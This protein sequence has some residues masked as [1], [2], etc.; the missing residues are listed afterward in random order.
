MD[1]RIRHVEPRD[2]AGIKALLTDASVMLG[3]M[4]LPFATDTSVESRIVPADGVYKLVAEVDSEVVGFCIMTTYP[5]TRLNR[6]CSDSTVQT[7]RFG[8]SNSV[9]LIDTIGRKSGAI[10]IG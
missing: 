5:D 1:I 4:R 10:L 8:A 3:T 9:F 2:V 6:F 7:L